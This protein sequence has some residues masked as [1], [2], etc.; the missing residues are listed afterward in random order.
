MEGK[1]TPYILD[2]NFEQYLPVIPSEVIFFILVIFF[3]IY[4]FQCIYD[5]FILYFEIISYLWNNGTILKRI[6][7]SVLLT[8][9]IVENHYHFNVMLD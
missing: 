3:S 9:F 1:V 6:F 2:K 4:I 8:C 5:I 7:V